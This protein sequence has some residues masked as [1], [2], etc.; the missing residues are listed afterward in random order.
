MLNKIG[1]W[2]L[3]AIQVIG[4]SAL[5]ILILHV[6]VFQP[7]EVSGKSMYPYLEDK[8]RIITEKVTYRLNEPQRGDIVVFKYPLNK[9]EEFIK[10]IIALPNEELELKNSLIT[11]YNT[12][13]PK[14]MIIE[15]KYLP[16]NTVTNGRAFLTEGKRVKVPANHYFVMGDNREG[17]SD[18][19]QWGFITREDI[20]GRAV[21]RIWPAN[22]FSLLGNVK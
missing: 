20:V 11:I 14:G 19:R 17:S 4:I 3:D 2:L 15:E 10:R 18:S 12:N 21:I 5:T 16:T 1:M 6:Y 7:N 8:D 13:N 9:K 22:T